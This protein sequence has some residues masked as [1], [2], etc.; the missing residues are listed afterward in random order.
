MIQSMSPKPRTMLICC[1]SL[2]CV[3]LTGLFSGVV[4]ATTIKTAAPPPFTDVSSFADC[5]KSGLC[6]LHTPTL[7]LAALQTINASQPGTF[8]P[9]RSLFIA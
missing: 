4:L 1:R 5:L 2:S 3:L 6:R 9:K 7:A 8:D